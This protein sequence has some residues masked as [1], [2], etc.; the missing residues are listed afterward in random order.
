MGRLGCNTRSCHGS[1][2]GQGGLAALPLRLRLQGRPRDP[3]QGRHRARRPSMTPPQLENPRQAH[4][5]HAPQGGQADGARELAISPDPPL[6]RGRGQGR[7][8][9][10]RTSTASKSP[11]RRSQSP[12]AEGEKVALKVIAHWSDGGSEDVTCLTRFR[13]NDES[14]ADRQRGRRR[15]PRSGPATPTSSRSTTTA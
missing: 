10:R 1:F 3:A 13:T 5:D 15:S 12:R 11:R 6:D 14:I 9:R 7:R 4:A 2:Q 8:A